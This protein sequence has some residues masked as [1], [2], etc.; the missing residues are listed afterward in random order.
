V[1]KSLKS[2]VAT[3]I[4]WFN[5]GK[6]IFSILPYPQAPEMCSPLLNSLIL[7]CQVKV[8]S[9]LRPT[10]YTRSIPASKG[11]TN[12]KF[13]ATRN[14]FTQL[15]SNA[16]LYPVFPF[17]LRQHPNLPAQNSESQ[18]SSLMESCSPVQFS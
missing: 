7:I 9:D 11:H 16:S 12:F 17:T 3:Q 6:Y 15:T 13:S 8:H 4:S 18:S 14:L 1:R 5:L 10:I 2:V